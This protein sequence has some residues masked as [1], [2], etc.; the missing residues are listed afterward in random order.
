[1]D[2]LMRWLG[3]QLD[4]DATR[5][6]TAPPGPWTVTDSGSIVAADGQR[7]VCSVGGTVDG[8]VSRWPEGP[9]VEHVLTHDPAQ[10]LREIDA[11]RRMIGRIDSHATIMGWDEVHGDLLRSLALPY[12]DRPGYKE[13][14]R[15]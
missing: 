7:V 8:R 6:E 9:T 11:K 4:T 15:P 10:V 12:A 13:T 14:W 1:M 5:A 3:K 2:D